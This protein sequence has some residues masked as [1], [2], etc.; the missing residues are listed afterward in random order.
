MG[1]ML[2]QIVA[3]QH[4]DQKTGDTFMLVRLQCRDSN[5]QNFA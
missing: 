5:R 2:R 3:L 1:D 4:H